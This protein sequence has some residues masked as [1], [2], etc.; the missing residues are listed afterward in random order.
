MIGDRLVDDV[1]GALGVGMRAIWKENDRPWP[2]PERVSPSAT[3]RHLGELPDLLRSL[4]AAPS[5]EFW[6]RRVEARYFELVCWPAFNSSAAS[7]S[8]CA[9]FWTRRAKCSSLEKRASR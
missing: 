4:A 6:S 3:L 9:S 7:R 5:G 1:T 2:R 8:I